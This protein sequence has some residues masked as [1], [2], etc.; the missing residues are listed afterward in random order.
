MPRSSVHARVRSPSIRGDLLRGTVARFVSL[1]DVKLDRLHAHRSAMRA[2]LASTVDALGPRR[3]GTGGRAA[4]PASRCPGAGDG[5]RRR[6]AG[7]LGPG[8]ADARPPPPED[9]LRVAAVGRCAFTGSAVGGRCSGAVSRLREHHWNTCPEQLTTR[10]G[11]TS[12]PSQPQRRIA[13]DGLGRPI[14]EDWTGQ[15]P[16]GPRTRHGR[17]PAGPRAGPGAQLHE[18]R[19]AAPTRPRAPARCSSSEQDGS[20]SSAPQRH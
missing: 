15:G 5:R 3:G 4:R 10:P 14:V 2:L 16:A 19:P 8:G 1:H 12:T 7:P 6:A 17:G 20:G 9:V 11:P 13:D 18:R